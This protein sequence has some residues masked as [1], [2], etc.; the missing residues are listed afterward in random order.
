[1]NI[2][3]RR[4]RQAEAQLVHKSEGSLS[5]LGFEFKREQP[6]IETLAQ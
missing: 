4:D 6:A 2:T 3:Q 1:M 5:G